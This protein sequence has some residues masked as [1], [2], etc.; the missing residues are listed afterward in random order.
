MVK[1]KKQPSPDPTPET[2]LETEAPIGLECRG[3]GCRHFLTLETR[4][5][6]KSVMRRRECRHCGRRITTREKVVG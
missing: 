5:R 6:E 3:C 2:E 1:K 4:K